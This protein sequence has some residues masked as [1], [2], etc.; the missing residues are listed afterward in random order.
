MV[1]HIK[2]VEEIAEVIK[3]VHREA[4]AEKPLNDRD[5]Q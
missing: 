1:I 2:E 5:E 4:E 3:K